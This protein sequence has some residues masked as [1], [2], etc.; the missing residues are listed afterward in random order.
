MKIAGTNDIKASGP[1]EG[2]FGGEIYRFQLL[3][4]MRVA[5]SMGV[6]T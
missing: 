2:E 6:D 5:I 4:G 1:K 3:V